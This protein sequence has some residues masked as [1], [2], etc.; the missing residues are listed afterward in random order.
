M[1]SALDYPWGTR[2]PAPG[3]AIAVAPGV[4]WLRM[5][6]PFALDHIN[7]WLIEDGDG[8]CIVDTGYGVESTFALWREHF[9][10]TMAGRP[11]HRIVVT[12]HHPDHVGSATWLM[13]ETGAPVSMTFGEWAGGQTVL[14]GLGAAGREGNMAF[15]HT[16]GLPAERLAV[17]R[18]AK[19]S[20]HRGV[21]TLP[22]A[23][24]RLVDGHR[25]RIGKHDWRVI[26]AYG[27]APE[28]VSLYCDALKVL[29]SGDQVLPRITTNVSVWAHQP[30]ADPLGLFL[31]SLAYFRPLPSD[32]LVLPSHDRVF[33]GLHARLDQLHAHHGERLALL[34][35]ALTSPKTPFEVLPVLF[36]R[37][38]DDHQIGF[39][40]GEATAHLHRLWRT[41]K[42]LKTR[43]A[44]AVV[45][46]QAI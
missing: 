21:P 42:A 12:H 39:A 16:L 31:D 34:H 5:P 24:E 10:K 27:H 23:F 14:A 38:L 22:D 32:C 36:K 33:R 46:F 18:T 37:T 11:V 2:L 19:G 45:R 30:E 20:Y 1:T 6:L 7:L 43:D 26:V 35:A 4:H 41:G 3:E 25:I 29:I 9:A 17:L 13:R 44:E 28:H 8:W 40:M 15:L